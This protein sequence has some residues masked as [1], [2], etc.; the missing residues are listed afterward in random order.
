[1]KTGMLWF[2]NHDHRDLEAKLQR[3]ITYYEMK[4]GAR[5]A[6]CYMHPSMLVGHGPQF[7]GITLRATNTIL[8]YHFWIGFEDEAERRPAA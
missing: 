2:D 3:A 7:A 8:P 6:V 4:Y 1:M 5:P